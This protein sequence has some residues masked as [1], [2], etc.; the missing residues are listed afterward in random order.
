MFPSLFVLYTFLNY[1]FY[2][3]V[4]LMSNLRAY[5]RMFFTSTNSEQQLARKFFHFERE[6]NLGK[7]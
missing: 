3:D 5:P 7:N 1:L 4:I 2:C 6:R